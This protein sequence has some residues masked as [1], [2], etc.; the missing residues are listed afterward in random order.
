MLSKEGAV[1]QLDCNCR[2]LLGYSAEESLG[3][4]LSEFL[5]PEDKEGFLTFLLE[6]ETSGCVEKLLYK[7]RKK[8]GSVCRLRLHIMGLEGDKR[9]ALCE[10]LP[11]TPASGNRKKTSE[12][13]L[14]ALLDNSFDLLA[15][16]DE[17]G[18]YLY[19]SESFYDN[20]EYH[21]KTNLGYKADDILGT[22]CFTYMHPDDLPWITRQFE[23]LFHSEKKIYSPP[24]RFKSAAGDWRWVE[25]VVTNQL[26]NP[27]IEAI[28]VSCRDITQHV[29]TERRLKEMQLWEAL[30][31][32]E[33]KER[34]RIAKDLHDGVAGMLAAAKMHLASLQESHCAVATTGA[35]K[36]AIQLLE[37][38]ATEVRKT[39]HNLMPELLLQHGIDEAL[40]R[41]C[42]NISNDNLLVR[43][44]SWGAL[45]RYK[46][47]FELS[48]YRIVQELLNNVVRHSQASEVLVQFHSQESI[49][50]I[51][52]EDNGTGMS[53]EQKSKEG[54]GLSNLQARVDAINGK[55]EINTE[56][57][58]GVSAYLEF[59]TS[60]WKRNPELAS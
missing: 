41:F 21:P 32:G 55:L 35:F 39:S 10:E 23:S 4:Q 38:A 33:E 25:A 12:Q 53:E 57:G 17:K 37:D 58:E 34:S 47:S 1:L 24:F 42:C 11:N 45:I 40:R 9:I 56:I 26:S 7:A 50:Y 6:E 27:D 19:L 20:F 15:L 22:N 46:S 36:Q 59:D 16:I 8:D 44:D 48:V 43:Y 54:M 49:L 31:N 3:K 2:N 13:V 5:V 29:E 14:Q 51:T 28:I 18:Q 60:S 52:V 30:V